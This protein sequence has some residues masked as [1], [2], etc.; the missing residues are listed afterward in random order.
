K[1]ILPFLRNSL[2]VQELFLELGMDPTTPQKQT[3]KAYTQEEKLQEMIKKNPSLKELQ[4]IFKT[5]I[6]Y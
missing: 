6:I 2:G 1:D 3:P 4:K 5:R